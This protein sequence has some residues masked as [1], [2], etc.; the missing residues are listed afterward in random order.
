MSVDYEVACPRAC[1]EHVEGFAPGF[2]ALT[3]AILP[4]TRCGSVPSLARFFSRGEQSSIT[5]TCREFV[6]VPLRGSQVSA[7]NPGANLGHVALEE[8]RSMQVSI[9]RLVPQSLP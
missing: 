2:W 6:V 4:L 5:L 1:P 3:W 7:Q 9:P 8:F